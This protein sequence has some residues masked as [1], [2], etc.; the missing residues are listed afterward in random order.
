MLFSQ[1]TVARFDYRDGVPSHIS[2]L[3]GF[4]KALL[5]EKILFD[6]IT[7]AD[8]SERLDQYQTLI[9]SN[10]SCLSAESKAAIR[11][12]AAAFGLQ[13]SGEQLP[14]EFDIYM[15]MAVSQELT[16]A[17]PAGKRIPT[18]GM[19]VA[20]EPTSVRAVAQV[21]GASEAHYGPL[22]DETGPLVVLTNESSAGGRSVFFAIPIGV[23]Y[24]E[25]GI[26]DFRQLIADAVQWTAPD[27]PPLRVQNAGDALALTAFRQGGRTLIYLVNS[28][29]D[30][31]R[32][33]INYTIPS[34]G[35]AVEVDL[36]SPAQ[37]V[38]AL[39][40]ETEV[41]WKADGNKLKIS[42]D[43]VEYHVLLVID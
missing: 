28:V 34:F 43:V 33:P 2:E 41:S 10:A 24:R 26:R 39:G 17:I 42:V 3:K 22:G 32:L 16:S 20:V 35:V 13:Y 37:S 23:R 40:D 14:F 31:T 30:E 8:L 21:Q 29:R 12:F 25:F 36:D 6:V 11:Q 15:Q 4:A 27:Q 38:C 1:T 18:I 5:Q 19:Q 7:E 9:L